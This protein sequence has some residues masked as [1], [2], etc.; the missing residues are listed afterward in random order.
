MKD[1]KFYVKIP[2]TPEEVYRAL[3][4]PVSIQLWTGCEPQMSEVPGSE[5]NLY[6]G[7]IVGRNLSFRTNEEIVQEWYF[8][9][10]DPPSIV[11]YRFHS[12]KKGTSLEV[13][14][15]NIPDEVFE[16]FHHG[17]ENILI[18]DLLEFFEE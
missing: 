4:I 3:T 13:R 5:F 16:E 15:T 7:N 1:L 9:D 17:W 18:R 11:T 8:E 14:Q 12:D 6:D 2:A 10:Q